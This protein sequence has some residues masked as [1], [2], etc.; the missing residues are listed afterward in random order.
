M[1][2]ELILSSIPVIFS[3]RGKSIL[4]GFILTLGFFAKLS[5]L[6]TLGIKY[7]VDAIL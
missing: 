1:F 3:G 5:S 4:T 2:V 6:E 7:L